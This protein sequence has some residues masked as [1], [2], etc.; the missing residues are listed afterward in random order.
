MGNSLLVNIK[1]S[2]NKRERLFLIKNSE[3]SPVNYLAL[4]KKYMSLR[5]SETSHTRFFVHFRN[6]KCTAQPVGKNY[7]GKLPQNIARFLKLPDAQYYTG[8]C[9]RRTSASLL[10]D[11]GANIDVLKRHGG[12]K[13]ATVAEGYVEASLNNKKD[14][15]EK[16]LKQVN[17]EDKPYTAVSYNQ[18]STSSAINQPSTSLMSNQVSTPSLNSDIS[19]FVDV[20][21]IFGNEDIYNRVANNERSQLLDFSSHT[22]N[23]KLYKTNVSQNIESDT[24]RLFNLVNCNQTTINVHLHNK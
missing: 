5:N 20:A 4:C 21:N 15:A 6:K 14:I 16:L 11:A 3:E 7:F 1:Y 17:V 19:N 22:N 23:S 13:S 2:K 10:C 9:F 18:P 12:W 8:H 24:N